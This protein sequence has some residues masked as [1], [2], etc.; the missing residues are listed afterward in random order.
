M[1]D[2]VERRA[3]SV[4][5]AFLPMVLCCLVSCVPVAHEDDSAVS[6]VRPFN[7]DNGMILSLILGETGSPSQPNY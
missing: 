6:S 2:S 1:G 3:V 5:R 4:E 7:I